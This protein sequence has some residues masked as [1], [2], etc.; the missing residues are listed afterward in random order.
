M[1]I[2]IRNNANMGIQFSNKPIQF[3]LFCFID[4]SVSA[5]PICQWQWHHCF[6]SKVEAFISLWTHHYPPFFFF[7]FGPICLLD[8]Q[9]NKLT[10][11][12]CLDFVHT[13]TL[14]LGIQNLQLCGLLIK[15]NQILTMSL[16]DFRRIYL[17][18][19]LSPSLNA[20]QEFPFRLR[21]TLCK[22]FRHFTFCVTDSVGN[23]KKDAF[24]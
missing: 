14:S 18:K 10:V 3:G 2:H 5:N 20:L 22:Y 11:T 13:V 8:N 16:I 12:V 7:F 15:Q 19:T 1:K 17:I 23:E 4:V 21:I 24:L 6:I 9:I